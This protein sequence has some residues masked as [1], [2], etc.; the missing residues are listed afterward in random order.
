M[1]LRESRSKLPKAGVV[2]VA[3]AHITPTEE[4]AHLRTGDVMFRAKYLAIVVVAGLAAA[5]TAQAAVMW[6]KDQKEA[7]PSTYVWSETTDLWNVARVPGRNDQAEIRRENAPSTWKFTESTEIGSVYTER[8]PATLEVA[9]DKVVRIHYQLAARW[10]PKVEHD[11][12]GDLTLSGKGKFV[13]QTTGR[14]QAWGATLVD[15][16]GSRLAVDGAILET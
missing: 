2:R 8:Q 10:G 12:A 9:E 3:R 7:T 11:R 5:Q 16:T 15:K 1:V 4:A 13:V 6:L 14:S